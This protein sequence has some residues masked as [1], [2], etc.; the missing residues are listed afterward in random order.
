MLRHDP[1]QR[2][3]QKNPFLSSEKKT[4]EDTRE[5][6]VDSLPWYKSALIARQRKV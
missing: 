2:R 4:D 6:I 1:Q 5:K 3:G